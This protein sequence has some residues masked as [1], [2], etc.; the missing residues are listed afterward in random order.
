MIREDDIQYRIVRHFLPRLSK[1]R[2][3]VPGMGGLTLAEA[4]AHCQDPTTRKYN[5]WFDGYE[6][7]D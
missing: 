5:E 3:V 2:E 6:I 4:R 7:D 1:P